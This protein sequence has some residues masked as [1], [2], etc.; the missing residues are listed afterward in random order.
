VEKGP[1]HDGV[2]A[3]A[4]EGV[5]LRGDHRHRSPRVPYEAGEAGGPVPPPG[6]YMGQASFLTR[7]YLSDHIPPSQRQGVPHGGGA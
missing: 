3:A 1:G 5:G 2:I 6:V 4:D 7:S